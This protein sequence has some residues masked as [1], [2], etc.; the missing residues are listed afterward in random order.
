MTADERFRYL[1]YKLIPIHDNRYL[2]ANKET[3]ADIVYEP[4][5]GARKI[6]SSMTITEPEVLALAELVKENT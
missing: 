2:Y 3:D 6:G 4:G 5:V 1:G